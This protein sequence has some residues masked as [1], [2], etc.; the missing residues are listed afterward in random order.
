MYQ[1]LKNRGKIIDNFN[2]YLAVIQNSDAAK[3]AEIGD[4][5]NI[6][7][8]SGD[9]ITAKITY[10][11]SQENDKVLIVFDLKTLTEELIQYRKISFNI[12]WWSYSGLKVPNTSILE[13]ENGLKYVVRKK[14]GENE[15]VLVKVLK[16]NDKY[17][18]ISTYDAEEL[19]SLGVNMQDYGNV[20]KYDTILLYPTQ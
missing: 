17:S 6:T 19:N 15:K 2:C 16:K 11:S 14:S 9:E 5:V 1:H 10:I 12:T 3:N 4:E 8:S 13:D 20:S 7:L 18:I